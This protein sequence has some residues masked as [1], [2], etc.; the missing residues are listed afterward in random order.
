M[1]V[2]ARGRVYC[3]DSET[4]NALIILITVTV[5]LEFYLYF[6]TFSPLGKVKVIMIWFWYFSDC[7]H[8]TGA[9]VKLMKPCGRILQAAALAAG[10]LLLFTIDRGI[11]DFFV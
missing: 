5:K 2:E 1:T 8:F 3:W 9:D 6:G 11:Q 7:C 10:T 4:A